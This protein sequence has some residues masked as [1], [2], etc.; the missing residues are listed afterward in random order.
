MA[1]ECDE[2]ATVQLNLR[3][4]VERAVVLLQKLQ[5]VCES[6]NAGKFRQLQQV[7]TSPLFRSVRQVYEQVYQTVQINGSPDIRAS[8]TA[9]ATVA[10][11]AAG[12]QHAH[13]RLVELTKPEQEGKPVSFI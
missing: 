2:Q 13:P 11:F 10:V 8:A 3:A 9:K 1:D 7:L 12:E 6:E 4:D 5:T